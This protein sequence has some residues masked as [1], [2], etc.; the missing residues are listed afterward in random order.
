MEAELIFNLWAIYDAD[1]GTVYGLSGKAYN[2]SG[3]DR[4]KLDFLKIASRTDYVTAKRYRV[5]ERF[6]ITFSDAVSQRGV[7]YL[8]AVHDPNAQLFE[9]VF[10]HIEAELPP[11]P[12]FSGGDVVNVRQTI[13]EDPLCVTTVLYEDEVGDIRPVITDEDREWIA[14]HQ[15]MVLGQ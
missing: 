6:S 4:K 8:N 10:Q 5:P 3:T 1:S 12:D 14:Q 9:E 7:T 15:A 13:P 11:L 2:L